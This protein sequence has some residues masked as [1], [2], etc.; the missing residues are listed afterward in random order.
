MTKCLIFTNMNKS[1]LPKAD[2][3]LDAKNTHLTKLPESYGPSY[4]IGTVGLG[5]FFP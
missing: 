1:Y 2:S 4:L 3:N 5:F